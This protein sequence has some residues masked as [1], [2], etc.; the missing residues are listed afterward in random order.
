MSHWVKC[1]DSKSDERVYVNIDNAMSVAR[2]K[3]GDTVIAFPGGKDDFVAVKESPEE[4]LQI[5]SDG[6]APGPED[7]TAAE[8]HPA[9]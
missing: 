8:H 5:K 6:A 4:L 2:G 7:S 3:K 1:T 9:D